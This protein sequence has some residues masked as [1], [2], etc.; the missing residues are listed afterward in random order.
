MTLEDALQKKNMI[1]YRKQ[2]EAAARMAEILAAFPEFA[3][4]EK[5]LRTFPSRMLAIYKSKQDIQPKLDRLKAEIDAINSKKRELLIEN[6]YG[7]DYCDP[8]FECERC[9][10]TGYDGDKLCGC[11]K[12]MMA[13]ANYAEGGIGKALM[14]K[15]F[16][17]F[18]L[19]FYSRTPSRQGEESEYDA[20]ARI[21]KKCKSFAE[22]FPACKNMLMMGGT[23][24]GKTHLSAAMAKE[25]I[26]RGYTAHYDTAPSVFAC[27]DAVRFGRR[28]QD[29]TNVYF[30]C[31]LLIID[32]LGA[33][34]TSAQNVSV[35]FE[36][37]NNRML[38]DRITVISTNLSFSE[39]KRIYNDRIASRLM[40]EYTLLQFVGKDVRG[41]KLGL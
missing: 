36:L 31:D 33:E 27:F 4:S 19:R 26:S 32:D 30:D 17:N 29:A 5:A 28:E 23:G 16:E 24:L 6:G 10:D 13:E 41:Q 34:N 25:V 15:T 3:E 14:D 39:I 38:N 8:K 35:L 11:V 7:E 22:K 20:M 1:R 18:S 2:E 37:I 9:R 12:R 40:G 21:L